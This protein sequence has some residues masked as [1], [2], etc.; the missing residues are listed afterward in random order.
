MMTVW[1]RR[2]H[3]ED[4]KLYMLLGI[5]KPNKLIGFRYFPFK[6]LKVC[7]SNLFAHLILSKLRNA[8]EL[9]L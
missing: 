1:E 6:F 3:F 7:I 2:R 5:F 8:H 4:M 9:T